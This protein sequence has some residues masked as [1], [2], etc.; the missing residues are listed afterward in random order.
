MVYGSACSPCRK[1]NN[2]PG[3][4]IH[5]VVKAAVDRTKGQADRDGGHD[6]APRAEEAY[7][8]DRLCARHRDMG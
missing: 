8:Q 1:P 6:E 3:K 2:R 7:G 5:R 4:D